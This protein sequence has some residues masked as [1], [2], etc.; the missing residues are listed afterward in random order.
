MGRLRGRGLGE[1]QAWDPVSRLYKSPPLL[2]APSDPAPARLT[3]TPPPFPSLSSPALEG[4]W[5]WLFGRTGKKKSVL[6][7]HTSLS[8]NLSLLLSHFSP[9]LTFLIN[10]ERL[11]VT[12]PSL[13]SSCTMM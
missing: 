6:T 8:D 4:R 5:W 3:P 2:G 9:L 12:L 13:D 10:V 1:G 11:E 7:F